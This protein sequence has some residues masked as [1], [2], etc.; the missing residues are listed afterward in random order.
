MKHPAL[1]VDEV[2]STDSIESGTVGPV[3]QQI[4]EVDRLRHHYGQRVALDDVSF[5]IPTGS[6][7][8]LLGPNGGGKTTLFRILTT[9]L[10][11]SAGRASVCGFDTCTQRAEVRRNIGVI[12]QSPSLDIYLTVRENLLHAGHLFGI[13]GRDLERRIIDCLERLRVRDRAGDLVKTLSGGLRR[14]VELAKCLLHQPPLL[15]LDEPS[16]GL[17]PGARKELWQQLQALRES[18]GATILLTTHFIDEA[19]RCDQLAFLDRGRLAALGS[20]DELRSRIGG[21]C[22]SI[23]CEDPADLR[24]RVVARLACP[25]SVVDGTVRIETSEGSVLVGRLMESFAAD[26]RSIT[27]GKPTLEDV[28][29][30]ET[31]HRLG[32]D[33]SE[34]A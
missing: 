6:C 22:V 5:S 23:D 33:S 20:P 14:R 16:T 12:F 30:R 13:S 9:L 28:F 31:G 18:T 15:I 29:L 1:F 26:I 4:V 2:F 34:A 10:T 11:P 21:D 19:D 17:D 25:A 7:F 8:G 3:M 24:E 27:I 32:G